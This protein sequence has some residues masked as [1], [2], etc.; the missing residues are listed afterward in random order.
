[1]KNGQDRGAAPVQGDKTVGRTGMSPATVLFK[2]SAACEPG[3]RPRKVVL[4]ED[5]YVETLQKIITRDYMPELYEI[6]YGSDEKTIKNEAFTPGAARLATTKR[7]KTSQNISQAQSEQVVG[8]KVKRELTGEQLSG[9][10]QRAKSAH[11]GQSPTLRASKAATSNGTSDNAKKKYGRQRDSE[12]EWD[13]SEDE[14]KEE[15]TNARGRAEAVSSRQEPKVIPKD[16]LPLDAFLQMY[17]SEDN[18][19]VEGLFEKEQTEKRRWWVD[20]TSSLAGQKPA[21]SA[22]ADRRAN[23]AQLA[24]S[25]PARLV[26][27]TANPTAQQRI[28]QLTHEPSTSLMTHQSNSQSSSNTSHSALVDAASSSTLQKVQVTADGVVGVDASVLK[29]SEPKI[30]P[31]NTRFPTQALL[32][33]I[34][35]QVQGQALSRRLPTAQDQKWDLIHTPL[36]VA[37]SQSA[38]SSA[39]SANTN[40]MPPIVTWGRIAATPT[41]LWDDAEASGSSTE[42]SRKGYRM[43]DAPREAILFEQQRQRQLQAKRAEEQKRSIIERTATGRMHRIDTLRQMTPVDA[44]RALKASANA[45]AATGTARRGTS[46]SV[47]TMTPSVSHIVATPRIH[48]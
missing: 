44:I 14:D 11:N 16:Q 24:S 6:L 43:P 22:L 47:P 5:E 31:A 7:V 21:Q 25:G 9:A 30:I 10:T 19:H 20:T 18:D 15:K 35:A 38:N 32:D 3:K 4:D 23:P 12:S 46:G 36:V 40:Y 27:K 42:Q 13:T 45:A 1:M 48:K 26:D 2:S 34:S 29:P 37:G 17:T 39:S 8:A 41:L 33:Q 28:G